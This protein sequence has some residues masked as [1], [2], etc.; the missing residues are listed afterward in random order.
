ME[1]EEDGHVDELLAV[2]ADAAVDDGLD[3]QVEALDGGW[4]VAGD[5]LDVHA[6]L[7]GPD[8][9]GTC[10]LA[11]QKDGKVHLAADELPAGHQHQVGR[12]AF[13][14]SLLRDE[15]VAE[16]LLRDRSGF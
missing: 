12:Q 10:A 1:A 16:H 11:V 7:R 13:G 5:V 15:P 2:D 9:H 4:V 8:D 6:P 3:G 14:R